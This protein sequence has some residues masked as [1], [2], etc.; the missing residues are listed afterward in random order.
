M[1]SRLRTIGLS[2]FFALA[3]SACKQGLNE[4][5]QVKDDCEGD[6]TCNTSTGRCQP[7][8]TQMSDAAPTPD[9]S[10]V[11]AAVPD[12]SNIDAQAPDA[13]AVDAAQ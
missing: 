12:A 1:A 7:E 10:G 5:C 2:L 11:D 8:G 6:L 13:A 9:G 4:I 3:L